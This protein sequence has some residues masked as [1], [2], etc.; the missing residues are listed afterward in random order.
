MNEISLAQL[1]GFQLYL[2]HESAGRWKQVWALLKRLLQQRQFQEEETIRK[3]RR[4]KIRSEKKSLFFSDESRIYSSIPAVFSM[5]STTSVK[6]LSSCPIR[7]GYNFASFR[8]PSKKK[9][10]G[11]T[12]SFPTINDGRKNCESPLISDINPELIGLPPVNRLLCS[13]KSYTKANG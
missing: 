3:K 1:P 10:V 9:F 13:M 5:D 7:S 2:I 8:K 4:K 6:F 11:T 12:L